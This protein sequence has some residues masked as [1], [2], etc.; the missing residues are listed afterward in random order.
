[1]IPLYSAIEMKRSNDI[2]RRFGP[3]LDESDS[4]HAI[5]DISPDAGVTQ[6]IAV[7]SGLIR[8]FVRGRFLRISRTQMLPLQAPISKTRQTSR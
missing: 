5:P 6:A 8:R 1:M 7:I 4:F 2:G 3:R